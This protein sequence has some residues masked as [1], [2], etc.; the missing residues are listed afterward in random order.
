MPINLK[1]PKIGILVLLLLA[2]FTTATA[3][4]ELLPEK[5]LDRQR[6]FQ[7][8]QGGK[9]PEAL[10]YFEQLA[11]KYP[12]DP[13]V[14]ETLG[15]LVFTQSAYL[16]TPEERKSARKRGRA[17]LVQAQKLG[18][19]STMLK[20]LVEGI[21]PDGGEDGSFSAKKEVDEAMHEGEAAFA[22]GDFP[23]AI[24]MYQRALL[25][26]PKLYE[27]ALFTGDVYYK[28]ADQVKAGEWFAR[29]VA[30]NPDRETAYRY[31]GDSLMKQGKVTEAGEKFVEAYIAEPYNRL[32]RAGFVNWGEKVHVALAHPRVELPT[33]VTSKKEGEAT[34]T[35]DPNLFGKDKSGSAVA[36]MTYGL[37]R[38]SW[39]EEFA[40]QYPN[41]KAYRHSLKEEASAMRSALKVVSE[42]K[43]ADANKIDASLQVIKKLEKEGLLEAFILL[44][45]PDQG[46]ATDF[47]AY[48]KSNVED[49]RRYVKQYVMTGG[50]NQ[51]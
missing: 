46:I 20:A 2:S 37:T 25:L 11:L 45:L 23:K 8:Y 49:L 39:Q 40:K 44:A 32:A 33:N 36:W 34:L 51:K 43:P 26:D 1:N 4:G 22:K 30:I 27:A 10:P 19:N 6:A 12:D 5:D 13:A 21:P 7:L 15:M 31:W 14:I 50:G 48:R 41:E 35:I 9:Y 24:E 16:K 3:Q 28:T 38:A 17:L 47:P 18:A 42:L 29:A